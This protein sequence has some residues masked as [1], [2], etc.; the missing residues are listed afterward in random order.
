MIKRILV[1]G[2]NG[3]VGTRLCEALIGRGYDVIGVD[4]KANAWSRAVDGITIRQD[5]LDKEGMAARVPK[6]VDLIIHLAANPR[7][8]DLVINPDL[9]F[10]NFQMTFNTLEFARKNGIKRFMFSSSREVYGNSDVHVNHEDRLHVRLC[11]SPYT[12]SKIADEARIWAYQRCYG[13][14]TIIFRFSNVYG[15]YDDS[16]RVVPLFIRKAKKDEPITVFGKEKCLDFTYI[17]DTVDGIMLALEKFESVNNNTFNLA[18]GQGV[19]ILELAE[20]V[21]ALLKSKSTIDIGQPRTGEVIRYVADISKAK[22]NLGYKPLTSFKK[23]IELAIGWYNAV[24]DIED[25]D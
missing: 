7:V 24:E 17:D 9:A 14:E 21:K 22:R 18:Y 23:G 2:S 5:L 10:E 6:D 15:M 13:L 3:T 16:E 20:Q 8:H 11:A 1:T 25:V 19:T 12:A 4:K